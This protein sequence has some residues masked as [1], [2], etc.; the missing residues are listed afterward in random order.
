MEKDVDMILWIVG[1][2][3]PHK[4]LNLMNIAI[5]Y[6]IYTCRCNN[7][8]PTV[9]SAIG[10]IKD[11]HNIEHSTAVKMIIWTNIIEKG[12]YWNRCCNCALMSHDVFFYFSNTIIL[13]L[14]LRMSWFPAKLGYMFGQ[15]QTSGEN[16]N[17][18]LQF[19]PWFLY[20]STFN[21]LKII[22]TLCLWICAKRKY[23]L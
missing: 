4:P 9:P 10:K 15:S 6:Y 23:I 22:L 7:R 18:C 12:S 17:Q 3:D 21:L 11:L 8:Q 14:W 1:T 2:E 13:P 20:F 5:N 16:L 19:S